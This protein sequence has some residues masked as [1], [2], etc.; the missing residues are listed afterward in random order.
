MQI[1]DSPAEVITTFNLAKLETLSSKKL[2]DLKCVPSFEL[3]FFF[4]YFL[5]FCTG[6]RK[7]EFRYQSV[8][9]D[10]SCVFVSDHVS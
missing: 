5:S 2:Q 1:T 9:I 10:V 3:L 6:W 7:I 8:Q 4:I